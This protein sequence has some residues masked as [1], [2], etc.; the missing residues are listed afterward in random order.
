MDL[1]GLAV[2]AIFSLTSTYKKLTILKITLFWLNYY[3]FSN[4]NYP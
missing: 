3:K 4:P 1:Y 2:I